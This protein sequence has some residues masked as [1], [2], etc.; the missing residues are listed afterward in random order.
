MQD[1]NDAN[2]M[3]KELLI[4]IIKDFMEDKLAEKIDKIPIELRP[5]GEPSSRCCTY[6][7]RAVLKYIGD[8]TNY[9]TQYIR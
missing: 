9:T 4:R 8:G 1:K 2:R 6:K 3:R 5:K 7:D